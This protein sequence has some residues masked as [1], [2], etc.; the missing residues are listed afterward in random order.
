MIVNFVRQVGPFMVGPVGFALGFTIYYRQMC[1][2]IGSQSTVMGM[3]YAR[4]LSELSK[5]DPEF[6]QCTIDNW[7]SFESSVEDLHIETENMLEQLDDLVFWYTPKEKKQRILV[8][9]KE[10]V[11]CQRRI[12]HLQDKEADFR[13]ACLTVDIKEPPK[14]TKEPTPSQ[15]SDSET[16]LLAI[17]SLQCFHDIT[18]VPC[19]ELVKVRIGCEENSIESVENSTCV[20]LKTNASI[21][22]VVQA[23]GDAFYRDQQRKF[24]EKDSYTE[25]EFS[26]K[27]STR[28]AMEKAVGRTLAEKVLLNNALNSRLGLSATFDKSEF[29]VFDW[30]AY[31]RC[32]EK[33]YNLQCVGDL[34]RYTG[35]E[36][37]RRL[38][39]EKF[40]QIFL[41]PATL[42]TLP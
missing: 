24:W 33:N 29:E 23:C 31:E 18:N 15:L 10:L 8:L 42:Q 5:H 20:N 36:I 39:K 11:A 3:R 19:E 7:S 35:S 27:A 1:R 12:E 14:I 2:F 30:K 34:S 32:Q 21:A 9:V 37:L 6:A 40:N 38:G 4:L 25:F 26:P 41:Q 16:K 28:I 17:R 13:K 22:E